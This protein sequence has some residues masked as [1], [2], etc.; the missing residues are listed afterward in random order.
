MAEEIHRLQAALR[1]LHEAIEEVKMAS[2]ARE[3][4]KAWQKV[5]AASAHAARLLAARGV[6]TQEQEG[7]GEATLPAVP[8]MVPDGQVVAWMW[9]HEETGRVGFIDQWQIENGWQAANPRLRIIR[10]LVFAAIAGTVAAP[11]EGQPPK[12]SELRGV[13]SS[14]QIL[15]STP[16]DGQPTDAQLRAFAQALGLWVEPHEAEKENG[17]PVECGISQDDADYFNDEGIAGMRKAWNR[18]FGVP[19]EGQ[20]QRQCG[21]GQR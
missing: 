8:A 4:Q 15:P 12:L 21:G 14:D 18:A 19:A 10:P 11:A 5:D 20:P 16:A 13:L 9:Q 17:I 1:A 3:G 7:R 2:T 6:A